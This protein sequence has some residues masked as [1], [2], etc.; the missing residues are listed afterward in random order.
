[1]LILLPKVHNLGSKMCLDTLEQEDSDEESYDIGQSDCETTPLSSQVHHAIGLLTDC[2]QNGTGLSENIYYCQ[3]GL[4]TA[5]RKTNCQN[6]NAFFFFFWH[7]G[8]REG[9]LDRVWTTSLIHKTI[10][11]MPDWDNYCSS[12]A[13]IHVHTHFCRYIEHLMKS[14][15]IFKTAVIFSLH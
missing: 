1:M 15:L 2:Q 6:L 8:V 7:Q 5:C 14:C 11:S 12:L 13:P 4:T 3:C 9:T 10:F